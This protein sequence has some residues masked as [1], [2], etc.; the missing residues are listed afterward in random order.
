[1]RLTVRRTADRH[2]VPHLIRNRCTKEIH[3]NKQQNS[4]SIRQ[5]V[6][7]VFAGIAATAILVCV[8]TTTAVMFFPG[9][10]AA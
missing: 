5:A 2:H 9:L 4:F 6:E 10:G 8:V 3:M 1:M 7:K